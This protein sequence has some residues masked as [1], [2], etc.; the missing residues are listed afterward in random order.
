M[1]DLPE[2]YPPEWAG[3]LLLGPLRFAWSLHMLGWFVMSIGLILLSTVFL[4]VS[5]GIM[6]GSFRSATLATHP[7]VSAA[8]CIWLLISRLRHRYRTSPVQWTALV[9]CSTLATSGVSNLLLLRMDEGG[10]GHLPQAMLTLL[11]SAPE[12]N[13]V[14]SSHVQVLAHGLRAD[15]HDLGHMM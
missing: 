11:A 12:V 7:F 9:F 4:A 1:I 10:D 15:Q 2:G 6:G 5:V 13:Y 8:R 14:A 3:V